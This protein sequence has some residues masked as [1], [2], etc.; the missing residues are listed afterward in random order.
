[1]TWL[2]VIKAVVVMLTVMMFA[3]LLCRGGK[4]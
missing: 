1:M 2:F 4:V 3:V